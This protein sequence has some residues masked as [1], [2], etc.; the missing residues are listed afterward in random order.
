MI[1]AGRVIAR[2]TPAE[3]KA[4]VGGER[5]VVTLRGAD[6]LV[7]AATGAIAPLAAELPHAD[8]GTLEVIAPVAAGTTLLGVV[9]A[10]DEADVAVADVAL[11][12]ATLDDAFSPSPATRPTQPNWR[13]PHER[14]CRPRHRLPATRLRWALGRLPRAD[15]GATSATSGTCR[16]S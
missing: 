4:R 6:Q 8:A 1:D 7:A 14:P 12:G 16:R 11:R 5:V 2:G 13:S 10:L 3:L 15:A 9:R